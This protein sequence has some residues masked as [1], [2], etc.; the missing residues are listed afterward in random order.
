MIR[1]GDREIT[2]IYGRGRIVTAV[3]RGAR[4]VWSAVS[5]C[6]GAGLWQGGKRWNRGDGW[7]R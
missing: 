1:R 7:R 4:L 3:Y 2:G 6:F 5:S